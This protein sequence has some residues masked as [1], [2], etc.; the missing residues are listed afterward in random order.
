M[1]AVAE[2][3]IRQGQLCPC[4]DTATLS[5]CSAGAGVFPEASFEVWD[6]YGEFDLLTAILLRGIEMS[7]CL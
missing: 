7:C 6:S 1:A 5:S 2:T 4:A 3:L